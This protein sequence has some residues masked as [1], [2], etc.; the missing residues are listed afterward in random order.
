MGAPARKSQTPYGAG[1]RL[2]NTTTNLTTL[3]NK[4][5]Y[6]DRNFNL[7][8]R[9]RDVAYFI[10]RGLIF[11]LLFLLIVFDRLVFVVRFLS[12]F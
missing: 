8:L 3:R 6:Y 12:R 11:N 9:L 1:A 4:L 7:R 10:N 5:L 2:T